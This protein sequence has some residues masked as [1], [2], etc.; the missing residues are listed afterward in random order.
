MIEPISHR[1]LVYLKYNVFITFGFKTIPV[2]WMFEFVFSYPIIQNAHTMLVGY[3]AEPYT[4][5]FCAVLIFWNIT[6]RQGIS[7]FAK[8]YHMLGHVF[9]T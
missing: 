3:Y 4:Y 8:F 5:K 7:P 2:K 6:R 1:V 9:M